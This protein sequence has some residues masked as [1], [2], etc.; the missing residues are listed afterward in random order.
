[1][2]DDLAY[3]AKLDEELV[4]CAK[5]IKV[6]SSLAWSETDGQKFLASWSAGQPEIPQPVYKKHSYPEHVQ[7]LNQIAEAAGTDHPVGRYISR[8]AHSYIRAAR[9]LE[10]IGQPEFT[11]LSIELYGRPSDCIGKTEVTNLHAGEHFVQSV[12]D[13]SHILNMPG[14]E[15]NITSEELAKLLTERF[16][17]VFTQHPLE[18]AIAPDL[19]SKA[20]AGARRLRIRS[21]TMFTQHDVKQ[22]A[23]HEGLVHSATMLNGREQPNLKSLGLGS[24][25]TTMTQEGIAT[26]SEFIT[27]AI[28]VWR[29]KRI[30][31]RIEAIERGLNGANFIDIFKFFLEEGQ[32]EPEA[33]ASA[34]RVFR[35]GDPN[36]NVVFT[37]DNVYLEGLLLVHTFLR[38]SFQ[39]NKLH[40]PKYLFVGRLTLGDVVHLEEFIDS[41]WIA[42]PLY[43]PEWLTNHDCLAA[44]LAYASF[45]NRINL[46]HVNLGDLS[47]VERA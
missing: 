19:A 15:T 26:F 43:M 14:P 10:C 32:T 21:N 13:F 40:F 28:D 17:P 7:K 30:A 1:M 4:D 47:S 42:Q 20:A 22:L 9:M 12:D 29:L 44:Y 37:K 11:E 38:K 41:G 35:G 33:Y 36:G 18:V 25:R 2:N 5:H 31:L 3:F 23:V 6:L 39:N 16:A 45:A 8:T 24:P 27:G 34:V 46:S